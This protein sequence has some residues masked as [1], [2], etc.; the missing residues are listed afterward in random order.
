MR[1]ESLFDTYILLN[2]SK[3]ERLVKVLVRK[4]GLLEHLVVELSLELHD[5]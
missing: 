2:A 1:H 3:V 4:L 5:Q